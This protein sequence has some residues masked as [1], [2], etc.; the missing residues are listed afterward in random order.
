MDTHATVSRA[1][2]TQQLLLAAVMADL[3]TLRILCAANRGAARL[4]S[5]LRLLP[6][7]YLPLQLDSKL[8]LSWLQVCLE[9]LL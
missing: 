6:A 4:G 8:P 2:R 7:F 9:A 3:V 1:L 5:K